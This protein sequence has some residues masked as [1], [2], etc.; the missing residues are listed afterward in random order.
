MT[1][2][3]HER[4]MENFNKVNAAMRELNAAMLSL[5]VLYEQA[6]KNLQDDKKRMR[7]FDLKTGYGL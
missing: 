3:A 2:D 5:R 7:E 4:L 1:N 6:E